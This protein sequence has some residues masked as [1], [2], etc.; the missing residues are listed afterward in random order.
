M[1]MS[2][3][4]PIPPLPSDCCGNGC[5]PC[6]NDI[7][8]QELELWKE[9][10]ETNANQED[11]SGGEVKEL[12]E[13]AY[14]DFECIG[15]TQATLTTRIFRFSLGNPRAIL[16]HSAGQHLVVRGVMEGEAVTRQLSILSS[17]GQRGEFRLCVKLYKEGK[18][19]QIMADWK[20]GSKVQCRGPFGA[21]KYQPN[22][23][24]RIVMLAQ[25]TGLVPFIPILEQVLGDQEE[26]GKVRL[27]YSASNWE[28][29]LCQEEINE[30][31]GFWNFSCKIFIGDRNALKVCRVPQRDVVWSKLGE[32]EVKQ[33]VEN[34]NLVD[35][36]MFLVCGSKQYQQEICDILTT[37]CEV[38]SQQ[39]QRF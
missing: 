29:V 39:I 38:G 21:F 19:S 1:A 35:S 9:R 37:G 7:Y 10:Q 32:K 20:E 28:E 24:T 17:P 25:G 18:L 33:E 15:V 12:S 16:G 26:E 11:I 5:T 14:T 4:P 31:C 34:N 6:V 30:F 36:T 2:D 23:C 27:V 3:P 8:D 13:S 22:S